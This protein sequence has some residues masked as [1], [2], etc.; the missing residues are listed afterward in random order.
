MIKKTLSPCIPGYFIVTVLCEFFAST[1]FSQ[2]P[3]QTR[4]TV[5]GEKIEINGTRQVPP[6]LFG[7]HAVPLDRDRIK[8]WGI[9]AHRNLDQNP[10]GIPSQSLTPILM[11]CFFDRYQPALILNDP[12]WEERLIRIASRYAAEAKNLDREPLVEFWNEPYLNWA[13]KPGVNYDGGLYQ[14]PPVKGESM[15][16]KIGGELIEDMIWD[17]P[18]SVALRGFAP[19]KGE[20]DYLATRFMPRGLKQGDTFTWRNKPFTVEERWWGKDRS[21]P[22]SWWS[23]PVN[24]D[25]YHRMLAP[26]AR[27]LKSTNPDVTLVVGWGFHLNESNWQAWHTLH[28]P[29]ID[30]AHE[31]IDGYNEH[32]YGGNTRM[33]AGTYETAYAYTL[34]KHGKQLKFYNT[35]AG[36]MLDPERPGSFNSAVR[37]TP[38]EQARGAYTYMVRDVLHLIDTM[39]D[40]AITRFAHEAH[41]HKGGTET[42]FKLLRPLRG[43][44]MKT[45]VEKDP[46]IWAVSSLNGDS[47]TLVVFNDTY[48]TRELSVYLI[49]PPGFSLNGGSIAKAKN[50]PE[51]GMTL[52]EKT[53]AYGEGNSQYLHEIVLKGKDAVRYHFK[54]RKEAEASIPLNQITQY[55][56][57][58]ILQEVTP[59]TPASFHIKLPSERYPPETKARLRFVHDSDLRWRP[60]DL[61][62]LVNGKKILFEVTTDYLCEVHIPRTLLSDQNEIIFRAKEGAEKFLLCTASVLFESRSE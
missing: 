22:E 37:G 5:P 51:T 48:Q 14:Q 50:L 36:G 38:V 57:P 40:K 3:S 15:R 56:A 41:K 58:Q 61:Q 9:E 12:D 10:R 23:G 16:T 13:V 43:Q 52:E 2:H 45:K 55:P 39:P 47:Y 28:Q 54:L 34:G 62:I 19:G 8:E 30:F 49:A 32:H 29:L 60:G 59:D 6:G 33:V 44:L 53:L 26:F 4:I 25:F 46:N 20:I 42:A 7:T 11:D 24:R 18:R 27:T 35:E 21:Q 17:A 1:A 31:W